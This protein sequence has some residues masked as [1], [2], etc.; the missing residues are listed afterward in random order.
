MSCSADVDTTVG[1]EC[2]EDEDCDEQ[3]LAGVA[4]GFCTISC[5]DH[6]ECPSGTACTDS[7]GGVCLFTC[8]D[9]E[10]C[11]A[12]LGEEYGCEDETDFDSQEVWVC[13]DD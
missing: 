4:G 1:A 10:D 11:I 8:A 7:Q 5:T 13:L 2:T 6:S 3:C 9:D 12:L